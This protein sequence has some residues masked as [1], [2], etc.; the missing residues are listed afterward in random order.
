MKGLATMENI[1]KD[2]IS[3]LMAVSKEGVP[4]I[5]SSNRM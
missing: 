3:A 2:V 1:Q 5:F 4:N